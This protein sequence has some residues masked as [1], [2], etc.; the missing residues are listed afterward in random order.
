MTLIPDLSESQKRFEQELDDILKA[1]ST[2]THGE[3]ETG[4]QG[5][6]AGSEEQSDL[7]PYLQL[8]N[9]VSPQN[10]PLNANFIMPSSFCLRCG[11]ENGPD[12][13]CAKVECNYVACEN[14]KP[15]NIKFCRQ[16]GSRCTKCHLR[17]HFKEQCTRFHY[18]Q[19][20]YAYESFQDQNIWTSHPEKNIATSVFPIPLCI[21][22]SLLAIWSKF[23]AKSQFFMSGSTG[24]FNTLM[25]YLETSLCKA[26][27]FVL[28]RATPNE[29]QQK[30]LEMDELLEQFRKNPCRE[31]SDRLHPNNDSPN[32]HGKFRP[33]AVGTFQKT[34]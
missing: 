4:F 32:Y 30:R 34:P 5:E 11:E 23:V 22:G 20:I 3:L 21:S 29:R 18:S 2:P 27:D 19:W 7:P 14:T 17:G 12:C 1:R 10:A 26:T 13:K 6:E 24:T 31:H 25:S 16:L 28:S 8:R 15:H 9:V 33:F